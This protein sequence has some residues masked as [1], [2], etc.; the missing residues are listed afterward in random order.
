LRSPGGI[1]DRCAYA[2]EDF[3]ERVKKP[4]KFLA[5][6]NFIETAMRKCACPGRTHQPLMVEKHGKKTGNLKLL[7][8]SQAYPDDLGRAL[9]DAWRRADDDPRGVAPQP[10]KRRRLRRSE[11]AAVAAAAASSDE[12]PWQ[13]VQRSS[14]SRTEVD[15]PWSEVNT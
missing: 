11:P 13:D 1:A 6:S 14:G 3:G 5:T 4:Y 15:D 9:I 12:D 2:T 7:K 10:V 8:A